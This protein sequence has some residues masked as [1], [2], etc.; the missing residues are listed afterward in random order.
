MND[1]SHSVKSVDKED[2]YYHARFR[3]PDN[4][5]TIR[6]PDWADN[7]SDS[8]VEGSEVRMG[9]HKDRDDWSVQSVLI[10]ENK[11]DDE[12]EAEEKALQVAE[13]IE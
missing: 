7:A 3:D 13:K 2:D 12:S 10:P 8:V 6:T 11:V 4:F 9:K 1:T 5:D